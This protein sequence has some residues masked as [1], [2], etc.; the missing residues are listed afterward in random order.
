MQKPRSLRL[1]IYAAAIAVALVT[2]LPILWTVLTSFK[3]EQE[4]LANPTQ[5]FPQM[6]TLENYSYM[7]SGTNYRY[8]AINSLFV[9]SISTALVMFLSI[10][11]AFA[12]SKFHLFRAKNPLI[13]LVLIARMVPEIAIV[14]PLFLLIQSI[15]LYDNRLGLIIVETA[16]AY[17]LATWLLKT[18][19][20]DVPEAIIEAAK[21]D[22]CSSAGILA[23]IILPVSLP[24]L[25]STFTIT[26]LTAWNSFLIPLV[27]SKTVNS[28]TLSVAISEM[29]Y[30]EYGVNWGGLS[31]IAIITV[32]PVFALGLFAQKY[33]TSGL[34]AGIEK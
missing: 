33:L 32:L 8:Y 12:Y 31:A 2:L 20:D 13:G 23:K 5:A 28:K 1:A 30:G 16:L 17:P 34:T 9:A 22:G 27:F 18:F 6:W 26:F 29:A 3:T 14:I 4:I 11:S 10:S 15:G 24:A 19:F 21:I 7:L 25:A